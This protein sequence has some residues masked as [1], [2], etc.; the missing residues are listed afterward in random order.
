VLKNQTLSLVTQGRLPH[1]AFHTKELRAAP[2]MAASMGTAPHLR[3]PQNADSPGAEVGQLSTQKGKKDLPKFHCFSQ[4]GIPHMVLCPKP[5]NGSQRNS[6][7]S[8][9]LF[10]LGQVILLLQIKKRNSKRWDPNPSQSKS[11]VLLLFQAG[12]VFQPRIK[13]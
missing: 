1:S 3:A 6:V 13:F 8:Y 11:M 5:P 10:E 12:K 9:Q 7:F 4:P 2:R